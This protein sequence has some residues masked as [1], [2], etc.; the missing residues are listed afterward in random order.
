M[1]TNAQTTEPLDVGDT[2]TYGDINL[3]EYRGTVTARG[4][5]GDAPSTLIFVDWRRPHQTP[6]P[7]REWAPNLRRVNESGHT[8]PAFLLLGCALGMA[9]CVLPALLNL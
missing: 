1:S 4:K 2:V 7:V 6:R 5:V 9:L 3:R 8:A